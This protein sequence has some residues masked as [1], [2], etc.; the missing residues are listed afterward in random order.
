MSNKKTERCS[1]CGFPTISPNPCQGCD[2][3]DGKLLA[4]FSMN[5]IDELCALSPSIELFSLLIK[6]IKRLRQ[7]NNTQIKLDQ[8]FYRDAL[9]YNIILSCLWYDFQKQL[10]CLDFRDLVILKANNK[11]LNKLREIKKK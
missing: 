11:T 9:D 7:N 6:E 10:F 5:E 4:Q 3:I 2:R 1:Y 8:T